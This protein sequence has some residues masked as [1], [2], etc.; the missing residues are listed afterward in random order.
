LAHNKPQAELLQ[1]QADIPITHL[2][3]QETLLLHF[4]RQLVEQSVTQADI[5]TTHLKAREHL[6]QLAHLQQMY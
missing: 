1:A 6:L 5:G 4:Q 3:L 2:H